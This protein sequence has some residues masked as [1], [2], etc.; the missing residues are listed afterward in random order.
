MRISY[1]IHYNMLNKLFIHLSNT[2]RAIVHSIRE[3]F[4]E[5]FR[6]SLAGRRIA[7]ARAQNGPTWPTRRQR[8]PQRCDTF[9][10][11][12]PTRPIPDPNLG[13]ICVNA[14]AAVQ[15]ACPPA[16][17]A[18][19]HGS[20]PD[21]TWR[22]WRASACTGRDAETR[23]NINVGAEAQALAADWRDDA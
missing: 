7:S 17:A 8:P 16:Y 4:H 10:P 2:Q 3:C 19:P 14:D 22:Y 9:G 6:A 1:L 18:G 23:N 5:S 12:R 15:H 11:T 13:Q 20:D 21:A